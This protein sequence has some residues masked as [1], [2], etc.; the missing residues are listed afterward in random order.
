METK[1]SS[2]YIM[3]NKKNGTLYVGV[4]SN[5]RNRV[6]GHKNNLKEGFTSK[7]LLHKL[8]YYEIGES[9]IGA[10]DREKKIK[11][12]TRKRK[13]ESINPDWND[14]YENII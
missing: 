10:I 8:V 6:Y 2:A 4:T 5:L 1:I 7:Y 13:I 11:S 3:T 9:I 14:L 12:G